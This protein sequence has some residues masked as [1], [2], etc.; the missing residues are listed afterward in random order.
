MSELA[1]TLF[2][3][4]VSAL[5]FYWHNRIGERYLFFLGFVIGLVIEVGFRFLGYQQVWAEASL[6]GVPVWLPVAWGA[7]FIMIT[8][9]G[10]WI[11][12]LG[13]TD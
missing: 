8:R 6:F 13:I 12:G 3:L 11:R 7:G 10:A 5:L 2:A 4:S 1:L 9:L